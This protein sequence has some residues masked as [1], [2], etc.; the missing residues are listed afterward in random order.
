ML[1]SEDKA[2]VYNIV[3]KHEFAPNTSLLT[4]YRI[5]IYCCRIINRVKKL[6]SKLPNSR[7]AIQ[8]IMRKLHN[9]GT[10]I[11]VDEANDIISIFNFIFDMI[12]QQ[13]D[14]V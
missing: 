3:N 2:L 8:D 6:T 4:K 11:S 9:T 5:G 1:S 12:H 14:K 10:E 13:E 7:E